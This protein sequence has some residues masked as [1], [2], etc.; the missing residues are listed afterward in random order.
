MSA[1]LFDFDNTLVALEPEVDWAASRIELEKFLRAEG[2][3][4]AI[5]VEIPRG[6]LP[7]YEALR[8][9]LMD[10]AGEAAES[11]TLG[12]LARTDPEALLRA[13]STMIE[14]YEL[15]GVERARTLPGATALLRALKARNNAVAIITSN[16]ARTV[17]RWLEL[18]HPALRL[19]GI[20]GRDAMMPLKPAPDSVGRGLEL[21][22]AAPDDAFFVG[23][24]E[25]DAG[26]ARK[27]RVRFYGITPNSTQRSRLMRAG[28]LAVFGSPA[29]FGDV[30]TLTRVI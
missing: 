13:A 11:E 19:D 18:Q 12:G 6:N 27:A 25:A 1:W 30:L 7:L 16:S 5:F 29:E 15:R 21:C 24:S 14:N 22:R 17:E 10:D 28:S 20:V 3:G 9:R 2:V 4:E 26:A 8:A 23:D